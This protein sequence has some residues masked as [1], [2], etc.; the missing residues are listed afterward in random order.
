MS[1]RCLGQMLL[2]L[3]STIGTRCE[4]KKHSNFFM[5]F[6]SNFPLQNNRTPLILACLHSKRD[7][8]DEL[9]KVGAYVNQKDKVYTSL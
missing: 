9:L 5:H 6:C 8:M 4:S 3:W 1:K 2:R 7:I